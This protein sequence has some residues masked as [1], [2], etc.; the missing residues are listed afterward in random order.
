[1][2]NNINV[3]FVC[4]GNICRSPMAEY[5]FRGRLGPNQPWTAGS[6]GLAAVDGLAASQ[7]AIEVMN[8]VGIDIKT[9]RSRE[10]TGELIDAATIIL[11]MTENQ[12]LETKKR[13]PKARDRVHL[14][15]TIN[16]DPGNHAAG[17][18]PKLGQP[19]CNAMRSIAG[20]GPA[21]A[22]KDI[23]DPVGASVEFYRRTMNDIAGCLDGLI[24][25]LQ[26]LQENKHP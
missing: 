20:R 4:T 13:F 2:R 19:A 5:L 9:H 8:K 21:V 23:S 11:V 16:Q 24:R 25:Y 14:L 15:G 26:S 10:L 6:A 1:M 7:T 22:G 12:A 18:L 3:L 17:S